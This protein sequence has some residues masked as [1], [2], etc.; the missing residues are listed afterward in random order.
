MMTLI[1]VAITTAYVYSTAVVFGLPGKMFFWE[2]AT[3]VD[4]MLVGHW[5]E[6]KSIMGASHARIRSQICKWTRG[7]SAAKKVDRL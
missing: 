2:L 3:L 1:S 7:W 4:V 6:M 5:I